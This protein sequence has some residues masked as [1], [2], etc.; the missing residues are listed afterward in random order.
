MSADSA[1]LISGKTCRNKTNG[2]FSS[3]AEGLAGYERC[4]HCSPK[5]GNGLYNISV[6]VEVDSTDF[7]VREIYLATPFATEINGTISEIVRLSY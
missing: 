1:R 4:C 7:D 2:D 3:G 5:D 6:D